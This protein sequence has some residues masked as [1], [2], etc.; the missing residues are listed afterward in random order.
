MCIGDC[1][2]KYDLVSVI[3]P[4]YNVEKHLRDCVDSILAQ[5]YPELEIILVD[6]GSPDGSPA[7][8]D[9]YA[10]SDPRV[11]VIHKNNHGVSAAR[12]TG[13]D[14]A[15][16]KWIVFVDSDDTIATG[17]IEAMIE[18]CQDNESTAAVG[19]SR[20]RTGEAPFSTTSSDMVPYSDIQTFT[21]LRS[22]LF[23]WGILY[24][25]SLIEK[26]CLRFDTT[27]GNLE[28]VTWNICYLSQV[29]NMKYLPA[30]MYHY[31]QNPTSITSRCGDKHWQVSSWFQARSSIFS[32]FA[33]REP[34]EQSTEALRFA[35]RYCFN[36]IIAECIVGKL[37]YSDY[38]AQRIVPTDTGVRLPELVLDNWSPRLYFSAYTGLMLLRNRLRH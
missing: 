14:A 24:R 18:A 38:A 22:G 2:M 20:F 27:L 9:E 21:R 11:R 6:D 23:V 28:D 10:A 34:T 19:F 4:I 3:V 36:N 13:L 31:R 26:L 16:G 33:D 29:R 5:T 7:I 37:T 12:N 1:N 8:C 15:E 35:N 25:R 30:A 17:M 32:W